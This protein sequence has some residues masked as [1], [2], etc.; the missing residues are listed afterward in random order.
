MGQIEPIIVELI[1]SVLK[2]E[3]MGNNNIIHKA[4]YSFLIINLRD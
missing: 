4:L 3:L 1:T 2:K